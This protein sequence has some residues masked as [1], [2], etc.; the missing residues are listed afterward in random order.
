[1]LL[2]LAAM[3]PLYATPHYEELA[4]KLVDHIPA[5]DEPVRMAVVTFTLP[6]N[7]EGLDGAEYVQDELEFELGRDK[8]VKLVAREDLA[9]LEKEWDFQEGAMADPK[10]RAEQCKV[11]GIDFLV[12]GRVIAQKSGEVCIFAQLLSVS[13]GTMFTERVSWMPASAAPAASAPQPP[14]QVV[15]QPVPQPAPTRVE[16][17]QAGY[18]A[19]DTTVRELVRRHMAL[20]DSLNYEA[21]VNAYASRI[22]NYADGTSQS[23]TDFYRASV[24]YASK[25]RSRNYDIT[26]IAY[27]GNTIEVQMLYTCTRQNGKVFR[28]FSKA[29][30]HVDA[31]GRIDAVGD[32]SSKAAMPSFSPG[33]RVISPY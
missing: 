22:T 8:R 7:K 18:Y 10:T 23:F 32:N 12:R 27:S 15:Y 31:Y 14:P 6:E 5:Q 4:R 3:L 20:G 25:W 19:S 33:M 11:A 26:A 17:P 29:T 9:T 30:L 2:C 21:M 13:D 24:E 1:M 16:T 28:G